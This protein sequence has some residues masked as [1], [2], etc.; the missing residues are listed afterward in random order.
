MY[1]TTLK[2]QYLDPRTDISNKTT[3]FR[4]DRDTAYYPN[5]T[6][7]GLGATCA[8]TTAWNALGGVYALIRHARLMDGRIELDSVRFYNRWASFQNVNNTN[9]RNVEVM[10][11]FNK[12]ANGYV[13]QDDNKVQEASAYLYSK[14]CHPTTTHNETFEGLL[15]LRNVLPILNNVSYLDTTIFKNL[16]VVIEWETDNLQILQN[17]LAF[18]SSLTPTLVVDEIKDTARIAEMKQSLNT[19][20]WNAIEHD[21]VQINDGTAVA[22]AFGA[23]TDTQ[24]QNT[25]RQLNGFD[26]KILGRVVMMK[27]FSDKTK[28]FVANA[29]QGCGDYSSYAMHNEIFQCRVNG[30]NLFPSSGLTKSSQK[31]MLM[32]QTWGTCNIPPFGA[33]PSIGLDQAGAV[34]VNV[35]GMLDFTQTGNQ[36]ASVNHKVGQFDFIGFEVNSRINQLNIDYKRTLIKDNLSTIQRNNLGLDLHI[37]GEVQRSLTISQNNYN[38][39]YL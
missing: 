3:E 6:I 9:K 37:F 7:A 14:Y 34:S 35:N 25:N 20:V 15:D 16:K 31:Q 18:H 4:L 2:T 21:V 26:N 10:G 23:D 13:L 39:K 24:E 1:S 12:S 36:P 33:E 5:M 29:V 8:N 22:N 27:T 17:D 11:Q 32:Y 19:I 38:V 30:K 28:N